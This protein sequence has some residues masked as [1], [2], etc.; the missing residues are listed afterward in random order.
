MKMKKFALELALLMLVAVVATQ[1]LHHL[2]IDGSL[3]DVPMSF[4]PPAQASG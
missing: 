4:N 1:L 2:Y 3:T